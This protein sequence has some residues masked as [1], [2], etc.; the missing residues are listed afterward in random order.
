MRELTINEVQEVNGGG[1]IADAIGV[2]SAVGATMGYFAMGPAG[3]MAGA[4][5]GLC[6]GAAWGVGQAAGKWLYDQVIV[7]Y[8]Y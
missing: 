3:A 7:N 1:D 8:V 2:G 6:V 4:T 5:Y